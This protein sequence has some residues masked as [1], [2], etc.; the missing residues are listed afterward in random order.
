MKDGS[1]LYMQA[2]T[3]RSWANE[4]PR[5]DGSRPPDYER[6]EFLGD[7]VLELCVR[8]LLLE[9]FP[10]SSEGELTAVKQRIVTNNA[11]PQIAQWIGV[12]D[13]VSVAPSTLNIGWE[14]LSS[15]EADVV[16]ALLGALYLHQ[17]IESARAVVSCWLQRFSFGG[18]TATTH[19]KT[20][21][22]T[23]VNRLGGRQD[24]IEY[25][26]VSVEG[27]SHRPT[28]LVEVRWEGRTIGR[29]RGTSRQRAEVAS[30][31]DALA[32]LPAPSEGRP[33]ERRHPRVLLTERLFQD[34]IRDVEIEFRNSSS[35]EQS[36]RGEFEF[37]VFARGRELAAGVGRSLR[38]AKWAAATATLV[39]LGEE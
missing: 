36:Q 16:E 14:S 22:Q 6:L 13:W 1:A 15:I 17:G 21:L 2:L 11:L 37:T 35:P 3:H 30:A 28:F 18:S 26:V 34:G 4:K 5:P 39:E 29:G 20:A 12:R 10:E 7:A 8:E 9:R 23:R 31:D 19:P 32:R 27:E 38:A 24:D 33:S 25:A